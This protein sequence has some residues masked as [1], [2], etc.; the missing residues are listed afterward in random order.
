[1]NSNKENVMSFLAYARFRMPQANGLYLGG[2]NKNQNDTINQI[3][4]SR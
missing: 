3:E 4:I 2:P 1:M